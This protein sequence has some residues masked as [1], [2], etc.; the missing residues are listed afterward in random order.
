[1][2]TSP[3]GGA[4]A[5]L[6]AAAMTMVTERLAGCP[7]AS[8]S[9]TTKVELPAAVGVPLSSPVEA[10]KLMPPGSDPLATDQVK[11][12]VP[13]FTVSWRLYPTP[14]SPAGGSAKVRLG[15]ALGMM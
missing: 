11:G 5:T 6:G 13:S 12:A 3:A 15:E 14:T 4:K 2:L 7:L 8:V 9:W 10:V 1:M